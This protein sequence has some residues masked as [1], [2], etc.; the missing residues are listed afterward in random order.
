MVQSPAAHFLA[1][2]LECGLDG[3]DHFITPL[4]RNLVREIQQLDQGLG[5]DVRVRIFQCLGQC[6]M[7]AGARWEGNT[8][9]FECVPSCARVRV[10]N[11]FKQSVLRQFSNMLHAGFPLDESTL[12]RAMG[13]SVA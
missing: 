11:R 2:A 5:L 7:S 6:P 8:E 4:D 9:A 3:C 13:G 12:R 10:F 1:L